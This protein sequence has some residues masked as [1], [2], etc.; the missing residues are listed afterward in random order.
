MSPSQTFLSHIVSANY[1]FGFAK[2]GTSTVNTE[3]EHKTSNSIIAEK[4]LNNTILPWKNPSMATLHS[5]ICN[6][7]QIWSST[8]LFCFIIHFLKILES[9]LRIALVRILSFIRLKLCPPL[10]SYGHQVCTAGGLLL[11][12]PGLAFSW[13]YWCHRH[14]VK[15]NFEKYSCTQFLRGL[16]LMVT[17]KYLLKTTWQRCHQNLRRKVS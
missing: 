15:I 11:S 13:Y 10:R 2:S 9:F 14:A 12:N 8:F 1:Q 7:A 16:C 17:Y 5:K 3:S 4:H 6:F